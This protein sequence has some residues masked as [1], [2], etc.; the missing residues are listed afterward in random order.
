MAQEFGLIS[1]MLQQNFGI[2]MYVLKTALEHNFV[3][4]CGPPRITYHTELK[5]FVFN[6]HRNEYLVC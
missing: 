5:I 3:I 2:E 4:F 1:I 6:L